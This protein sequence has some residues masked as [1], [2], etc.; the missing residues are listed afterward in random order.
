MPRR[1]G[2]GP[3]GSGPMTG[4][5]LGFCN[6]NVIKYGG[7]G[8]GLLGLGYGC[9]RGYRWFESAQD[10][11]KSEKELLEERK[12]ILKNQLDQ[13]NKKLEDL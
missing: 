1:D 11:S 4:R 5:G 12:I 6:T 7:I 13:I 10:I 2:T 8:L 3:L 9:K